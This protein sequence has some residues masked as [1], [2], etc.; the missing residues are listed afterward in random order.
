M[1]PACWQRRA[2]EELG[3]VA[4]G[5]CLRARIIGTAGEDLAYLR[6]APYGLIKSRVFGRLVATADF[7]SVL[8]RNIEIELR[9]RE[10]FLSIYTCRG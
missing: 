3:R 2:R 7:T 6:E 8:L 1:T 9:S 5:L 10:T 4:T